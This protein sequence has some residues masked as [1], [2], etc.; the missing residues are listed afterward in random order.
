MCKYCQYPQ[1]KLNSYATAHLRPP[2]GYFDFEVPIFE[3]EASGDGILKYIR[4][5]SR[6]NPRQTNLS[7]L[8][9]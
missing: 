4:I 8:V 1:K 3:G 9:T 2:K 6:S 7:H 5:F